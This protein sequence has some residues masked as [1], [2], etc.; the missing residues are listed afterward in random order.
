M[1]IK[2]TGY[3]VLVKVD[4]FDEKIKGSS[5]YMPVNE[6]KREHSGRDTAIVV[7]F[8]P[9]CYE[10]YEG[11]KGP[12]D[13]GVKVGDRVEFRRYDGK[14]PAYAEENESLKDFRLIN[15][16]DILAVLEIDDE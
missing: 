10:G 6:A 8:G 2:P 11:C 7:E 1:K 15:D 3:H 12:E 9:R 5:L 13:W 16:G 14:I 4:S